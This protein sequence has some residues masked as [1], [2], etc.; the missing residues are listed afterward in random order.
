MTLLLRAFFVDADE[1]AAWAAPLI[2]AQV[3]YPDPE[4]PR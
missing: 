4:P 1:R 2:D 3:D